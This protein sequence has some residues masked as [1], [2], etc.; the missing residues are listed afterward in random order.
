MEVSSW[1]NGFTASR[2]AAALCHGLRSVLW[3]HNFTVLFGILR[4]LAVQSRE[5]ISTI[6]FCPRLCAIIIYKKSM[7]AFTPTPG[8]KLTA[9]KGWQKR[10]VND[11]K[12]IRETIVSKTKIQIWK[13][14]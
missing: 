12:A 10:H 11:M 13:D 2:C 6:F 9:S 7:C 4:R 3:L 14:S 8:M 5:L 1:Y